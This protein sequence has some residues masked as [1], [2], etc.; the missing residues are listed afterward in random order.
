MKVRPAID[1]VHRLVADK[2]LQDQS[3]GFPADAFQAQEAAVEPG[4]EQVLE[5]GVEFG[6]IFTVGGQL[7]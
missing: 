1:F 3:S 2:F 4:S 7:K 5:V 6:E